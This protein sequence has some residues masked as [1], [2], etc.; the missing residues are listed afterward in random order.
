MIK[1][2][3]AICVLATAQARALRGL[4]STP[5]VQLPTCGTGIVINGVSQGESSVA[6]AVKACEA[7]LTCITGKE[8][9]IGAAH[10]KTGGC[11]T[12]F[13]GGTLTVGKGY[14]GQVVAARCGTD[15]ASK[16][17]AIISD[18]AS[19]TS[20]ANNGA[21]VVVK[22]GA[23]IGTLNLNGGDVTPNEGSSISMISVNGGELKGAAEGVSSIA[24]NGGE[25]V[26][27]MGNDTA[28]D[29]VEVNGGELNLSAKSISTL[30]LMGGTVV[31][32]KAAVATASTMGGDITLEEGATTAK[33]Q[34]MGGSCSG[35]GCPKAAGD[36]GRVF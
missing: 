34:N 21:S 13:N 12:V 29:K 14:T 19:P 28:V 10:L 23:T 5:C 24:V 26:L 3:I 35:T 8:A 15:D 4:S 18:G 31:I 2:A 25:V 6:A 16:A 30:S 27:D 17:T 9:T 22:S 36:Q 7:S 11:W 1:G 20:V 32:R 33:Y